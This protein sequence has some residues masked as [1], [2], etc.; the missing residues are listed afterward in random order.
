[1]ADDGALAGTLGPLLGT[2][3]GRGIGLM[4]VMMG[5]A[6]AVLGVGAYLHPRIRHLDD[7]LPDAIPDPGLPDAIP[8][9]ATTSTGAVEPQPAV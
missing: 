9:P 5:V 6:T 4:I 3:D 1:M 8:E 2:G 7:D